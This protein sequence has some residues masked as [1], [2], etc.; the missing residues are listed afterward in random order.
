MQGAPNSAWIGR[1]RM[2]RRPGHVPGDLLRKRFRHRDGGSRRCRRR[3]RWRSSR[4]TSTTT[5]RPPKCSAL[6]MTSLPK[7]HDAGVAHPLKIARDGS[8]Q[9]WAGRAAWARIGRARTVPPHL[10]PDGAASLCPHHQQTRAVVRRGSLDLR[11]DEST[12]WS[13]AWKVSC[14]AAPPRWRPGIEY[15][16]SS[17]RRWMLATRATSRRIYPN[18]FDAHPP[19]RSTATSA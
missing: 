11:G 5:S 6:T 16:R 19:F 14:W 10:A 18:L 8:I 12:G 7:S 1:S 17:S 9:E 3:R 4:S 2:T 15:H 13:M